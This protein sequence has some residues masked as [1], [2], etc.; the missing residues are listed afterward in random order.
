MLEMPPADYARGYYTKAISW[1]GIYILGNEAVP[2][3]AVIRAAQIVAGSL[4]LVDPR[5]VEALAADGT[6]FAVI[7]YGVKIT[8][9]PD[10]AHLPTA[11]P[12]IDYSGLR[13]LGGV[14]G[15]PTSSAGEENLLRTAEDPY[16]GAES[17]ALHEWAHAIEGIG[18][19]IGDPHLHG[20]FRAAYENAVR[21]GLWADTYALTDFHEYFAETTQAFFNDNP[22]VDPPDGI[23]GT[24]NTRTELRAYDPTVFDLLLELFG[25]SHW[26]V[27]TTFLAGTSAQLFGEK[28]ARF[29][30]GDTIR[31]TD[32]VTKLADL[33]IAGNELRLS[34]AGA[35]STALT[36]PGDFSGGR[37]FVVSN[38]GGGG[39]LF[40]QKNLADDV[41]VEGR[42]VAQADLN[43]APHP[44]S[45]TGDGIRKFVVTLSGKAAADNSNALGVYEID[46]AGNILD[47]RILFGD[48]KGA[49][50]RSVTVD[51][52][53]A[54]H[55][56]GFFIVGGGT[57]IGSARFTDAAGGGPDIADGAGLRLSVAGAPVSGP[58]FHAFSASLNA[59]GLTHVRS[60]ADPSGLGVRIA[61]EDVDGGGDRDFQDVVFRVGAIDESGDFIV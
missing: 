21:S 15:L 37:F 11:Y 55:R 24:I 13:G 1:R 39:D 9:L 45:L 38:P 31:F 27:G 46:A 8:D 43:G 52:V 47:A 53:D 28:V 44:S 16:R 26:T 17:I 34:A 23:H 49:A 51:G 7:P 60:G 57:G 12:G 56:L 41:L 5:I 32:T 25:D 40:F 54:G 19:A 6:R 59:D 10:Y 33:L 50:G 42:A 2:D 3:E 14:I 48:V 61:F 18:L 29:G 4:A 35:G 22:D 30:P 58:V 20:R 36:L